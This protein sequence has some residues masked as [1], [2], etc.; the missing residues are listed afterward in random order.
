MNRETKIIETPKKHKV[1]LRTWITVKEDQELKSV[2]LKSMR[3][4][5]SGQ[6][7][8]FKQIDATCTLER[9]KKAIELLVVSID[10]KTEN[11]LETILSMDKRD[12]QIIKEEIDKVVGDAD[13]KK[14]E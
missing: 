13:F 7:V 8:S 1:E 9:E 3:M 14:P 6:G 2:L 4:E 5:P 11:I 12:Y 10:G